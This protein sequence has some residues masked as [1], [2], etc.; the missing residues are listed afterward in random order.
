M[1]V[2]TDG[3]GSHTKAAGPCV[4]FKGHDDAAV[5]SITQAARRR[6]ATGMTALMP[7]WPLRDV[8]QL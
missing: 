8:E 5:L 4:L 7:S 6:I 3:S 2:K 1:S